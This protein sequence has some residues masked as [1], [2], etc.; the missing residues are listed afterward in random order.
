MDLSISPNGSV[1]HG[2]NPGTDASIESS[3]GMTGA[4]AHVPNAP[5]WTVAGQRSS[6]ARSNSVMNVDPSGTTPAL[7][8]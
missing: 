4:M 2:I 1:Y 6:Q 8:V 5:F 3:D 7:A